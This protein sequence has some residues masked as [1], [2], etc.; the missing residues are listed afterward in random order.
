MNTHHQKLR[1]K[2]LPFLVAVAF[3]MQ[4]LDT[5][6]I[7]VAIASIAQS[8]GADPIRLDIAVTS[9]IFSVAI[10][11]PASGWLAD[12]FSI[13]PV[14]FIAVL[15]FTLGSF[16]CAISQNISQLTGARIVQGL[17]GAMLMPV[18]RLAIL[19]IV[20]RQK[21]LSVMS[22]VVIP[23]LLGPLLGPT[24]GGFIVE[25]LSWHW[26][27]LINIPVGI[28][29]CLATLYL[30]PYM[31]PV[32]SMKFDYKGFLL[33]D[34]AIICFF[35]SGSDMHFVKI[36]NSVFALLGICFILLYIIYAKNKRNVLFN[37]SMFKTR[38]FTVGII[39]NLIF[40]LIAG[41]LPFLA[42]LFLQTALNFSPS[43]TGLALIPLACGGIL[44]KVFVNRI[45]TK[46][47]YKKFMV[48]TTI[49]MGAFT[50]CALFINLEAPFWLILVIFLFIG[51]A[52]SM[53]YSSISALALIEVP[54]NF[55]S[56]ANTL[57]S[58]TMQISIAFGVSF[59]ALIM[60]YLAHYSNESLVSQFH[61]VYIIA[62]LLAILNA[63]TFLF[64]KEK[65]LS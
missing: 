46:F 44:A 29:C 59:C 1:V 52:N 58:V 45:L 5:S 6:I 47:G 54:N 9:F 14:F 27:F 51:I 30:M 11:L 42:P 7:N 20:P 49:A 24:V 18:G 63:V 25:Y 41:A 56:Q 65:N 36:S 16:L 35:L 55:L 8:F 13:G 19:R 22:F 61:S 15:I 64:I 23:G 3:F 32:K 38:N 28:I 39:G 4:M 31:K 60:E 40:M 17:G 21:Y 33:F 57:I 2:V 12:R 50:A 48:M 26:I 43:K 62:A 37:L 53:Q 10:L 34:L